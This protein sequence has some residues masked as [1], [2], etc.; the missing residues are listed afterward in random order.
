MLNC[1]WHRTPISQD[2]VFNL[3]V[4]C[5]QLDDE[6]FVRSYSM[7]LGFLA[8]CTSIELVHGTIRLQSGI[9][10][11]GGMLSD[12]SP[13]SSLA[14]AP[15][16][17]YWLAGGQNRCLL[18]LWPSAFCSSPLHESVAQRWRPFVD[19]AQSVVEYVS[20]YVKRRADR[21]IVFR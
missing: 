3:N 11:V 19:F 15:I 4:A 10:P 6:S 17:Y 21:R 12:S 14:N 16:H 13:D 20:S 2:E 7:C 9:L 18:R 5:L 8:A 1:W